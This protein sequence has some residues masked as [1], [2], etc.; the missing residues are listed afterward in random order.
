MKFNAS[1]TIRSA[2]KE[3]GLGKGEFFKLKEG[4]NKIRLMS[5]GAPHQNVFNGRTNFK[6]VTWIFDYTDNLVKLYFMPM[7]IMRAI[8]SLQLTEDY[9]F[10][11]CPMPYDLLITATGAGTKE[12]KYQ[13]NAARNNTPV[14]ETA[15]TQFAE[16]KSVEDVVA[17][18]K[19]KEGQ[20]ASETVQTQPSAPQEAT[21]SGVNLADIP[22]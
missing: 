20:S 6:F 14:P 5:N 1:E 18:L 11:E 17:K 15:L 13:V 7:S 16:K 3:F 2:E 10:D 9:Q 12:V 8:E 4:S 21:E 19:E 22:F